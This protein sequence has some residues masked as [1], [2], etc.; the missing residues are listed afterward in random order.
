[1]NAAGI[2]LTETILLTFTGEN[3]ENQIAMTSNGPE[4]R[5]KNLEGAFEPENP[6]RYGFL[7]LEQLAAEL[8]GRP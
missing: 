5:R 2:S 6:E 4:F 8:Q 3:G 7:L 1:M